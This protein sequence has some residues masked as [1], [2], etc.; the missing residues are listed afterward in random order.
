METRDTSSTEKGHF[1]QHA[2]QAATGM[3]FALPCLVRW[4]TP[5]GSEEA[6]PAL[7]RTGNA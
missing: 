6:P 1:F 4:L 5:I 2:I 7:I 3:I